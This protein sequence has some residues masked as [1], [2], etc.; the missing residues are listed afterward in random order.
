MAQVTLNPR[1]YDSTSTSWAST[2]GLNNPVGKGT[3]NTSSYAQINLKTG[4]A[5]E[6]Y[7]Y[8]T[9]DTSSIPA[10]ATIKSVSCSAR[11][12]INNTT[13]SRIPTRTVRLYS[14]SVAMGSATNI[15][16]TASTVYTLTVGSWTREQLNS[17]RLRLYAQRGSSNATTS[18]YFRFYGADLTVVYETAAGDKFMVRLSG[19]YQA[20]KRVLKKVSGHWVEQSN[21]REVVEDGVRYVNGG[22]WE[23]PV[24]L[25]SFSFKSTSY[26]SGG[27][28]QAEDGMTWAQWVASSYSR[29][30][31]SITPSGGKNYVTYTSADVDVWK[32]WSMAGDSSKF[33]W[34]ED[35]IIAGYTYGVGG[36]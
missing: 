7:V 16:S 2:S 11:L 28:F 12:L 32:Q 19:R 21:L 10:N 22:E 1:G 31:F 29:G 24:S 15:T 23:N 27:T 4:N 17:V 8:W 9:F 35:A 34:A 36:Y 26:Y 25:I 5:A 14:G 20:A 33:V 30:L 3:S 6:T 18:Y 13:S